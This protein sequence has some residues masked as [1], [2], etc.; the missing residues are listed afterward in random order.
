MAT[1]PVCGMQVDETEAKWT[2]EYEGKTY[3]FCSPGCMKSFEESPEQYLGD[4]GD[5]GEHMHHH[6]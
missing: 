1:D 2:S 5:S 3:Y 6:G 4:G